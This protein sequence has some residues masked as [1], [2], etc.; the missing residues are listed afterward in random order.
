MLD[1]G[2]IRHGALNRFLI[3]PDIEQFLV[4]HIRA[5]RPNDFNRYSNGGLWNVTNSKGLIASLRN[6]Q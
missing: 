3:T 2:R 1:S 4:D 6:L 5:T